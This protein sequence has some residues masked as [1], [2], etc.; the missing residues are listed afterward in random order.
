V[1]YIILGSQVLMVHKFQN[2]HGLVYVLDS[3]TKNYMAEIEKLVEEIKNEKNFPFSSVYVKMP[4]YMTNKFVN[5]IDK[6]GLKVKSSTHKKH[7]VM[8]EL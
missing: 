2:I 6:H 3:A 4:L 8:M 7:E 5:E 1:Y